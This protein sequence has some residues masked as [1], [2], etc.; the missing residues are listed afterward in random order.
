[1]KKK[2][3][4]SKPYIGFIILF[5]FFISFPDTLLL[6]LSSFLFFSLSFS[7]I[8][9]FFAGTGSAGN[10]GDGSALTSQVNDPRYC[11]ADTAGRVYVADTGNHAIRKI[12]GGIMTTV[13]GTRGTSGT[14]NNVAATSAGLN[15]PTSIWLNT[16]GDMF[17]AEFGN[18]AI[19]MV[20]ASTNIMTIL[21]GTIGTLGVTD[22]TVTT[23][24]QVRM[25][26]NKTKETIF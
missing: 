23:A 2:C 14:T 8:L 3:K 1:L 26:K 6:S 24:T 25:K 17:M 13:A 12:E 7:G 19:R 20:S 15:G 5:Y 11:Y 18:H 9:S 22:D 21:A 10:N 4:Y 16:L